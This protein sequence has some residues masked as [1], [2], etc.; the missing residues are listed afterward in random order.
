VETVSLRLLASGALWVP[1]ITQ[2]QGG[3]PA[4]E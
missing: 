3:Y 1:P 2:V 4:L